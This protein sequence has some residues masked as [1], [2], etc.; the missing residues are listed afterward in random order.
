MV[1]QIRSKNE[2]VMFDRRER[3]ITDLEKM[4]RRIDE[5]AD[6]GELHMMPEYIQDVKAVQKK[7]IEVEAEIQWINQ[8][9]T[10][11]STW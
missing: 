4:R 2:L 6:H 9:N 1:Q 10:I 11:K 5:F 3:L 7:L 8:V